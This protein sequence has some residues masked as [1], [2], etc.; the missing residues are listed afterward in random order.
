[1]SML[2]DSNVFIAY[3]NKS[4]ENHDK[5]DE[6]LEDIMKNKYGMPFTS[7]YIFNETVTTVLYRTGNIARAVDV[8][9][10]ILGNEE[11][12]IPSFITMIFITEDVLSNAWKLFLKYSE[13]KLSFTD[14]ASIELIKSRGIEYIASFDK[15]FNGIVSRTC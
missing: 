11:K 9:D 3:I 12:E 8:R 5:A 4:D 6:L 1:M 2:I 7:D 13:K 14:C 10:L 15:D